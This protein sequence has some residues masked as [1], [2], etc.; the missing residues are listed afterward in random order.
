M[1]KIKVGIIGCGT[2]GSELAIACQKRMSGDI[3]LAGI[4]DQ[5]EKKTTALQKLLGT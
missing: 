4:C 5:D 2:I 1:R 3:D